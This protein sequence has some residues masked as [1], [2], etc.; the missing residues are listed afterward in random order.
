M[1]ALASFTPLARVM[2]GAAAGAAVY[3]ATVALVSPRLLPA[4]LGFMASA[5][6]RG[7]PAPAAAEVPVESAS[8]A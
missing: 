7:K 8:R 3:V 1:P 5:A 6:R 2:L 4:M